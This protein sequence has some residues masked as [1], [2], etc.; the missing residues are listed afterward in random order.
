MSF[1]IRF[2]IFILLFY[3]GIARAQRNITIK[4]SDLDHKAV[5]G[6]E[7]TSSK[8]KSIRLISNEAET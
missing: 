8:N 7:G 1:S 5:E 4:I 3:A 6:V 2:L